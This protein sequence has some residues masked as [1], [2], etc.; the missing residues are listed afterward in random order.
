MVLGSVGALSSGVVPNACPMHLIGARNESQPESAEGASGGPDAPP[1][2]LSSDPG[3]RF[4]R[5]SRRGAAD[6]VV[7][8]PVV[9]TPLGW[10]ANVITAEGEGAL[11]VS[12]YLVWP[13]TS[14]AGW[15]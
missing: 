14:P 10:L 3:A 13:Q 6:P 1:L 8:S 7:A 5:G 11:A 4:A 15:T 12:G 2:L 9:L